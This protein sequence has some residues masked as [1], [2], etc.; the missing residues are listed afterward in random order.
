MRILFKNEYFSFEDDAYDYVDDLVLGITQ[1]LPNKSRKP[2]PKH[3]EKYGGNL[4]Y[5]SFKKSKQ[6]TWYVFFTIHYDEIN[7]I[8]IFL[9]RY[10]SNNHMISKYL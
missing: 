7:D 6:T 8:Q 2:A 9:I 3:F 1:D 4:Y 10:I 5:A